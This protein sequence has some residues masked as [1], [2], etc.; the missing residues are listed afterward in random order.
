MPLRRGKRVNPVSAKRV[1]IA[2]ERRAF[3]ERV[4]RERPWCETHDTLA[5][6]ALVAPPRPVRS[7]DV[8]EPWT[9]ARGGP[10]VPSQG[11][12]DDMVLCVCRACHAFCHDSPRIAKAF[13]FLR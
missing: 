13:G 6:L 3:V 4:L 7:V 11:L 12:S 1:A 8:H 5:G 10:I 9:R 2:D